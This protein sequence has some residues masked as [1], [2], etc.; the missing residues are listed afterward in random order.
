MRFLGET[1]DPKVVHGYETPYPDVRYK[2]AAQVFPYL[3]PTQLRDMNWYG[4]NPAS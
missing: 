4:M 3:I 1:K 2:A